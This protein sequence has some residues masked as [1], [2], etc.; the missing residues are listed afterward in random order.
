MT[1]MD[2]RLPMNDA[3]AHDIEFICLAK[4]LIDKVDEIIAPRITETT[5]ELIGRRHADI[6]VAVL[7]NARME[8]VDP[9]CTKLQTVIWCRITLLPR[10]RRDIALPSLT[11]SI[12]D[13][14]LSKWV[15]TRLALYVSALIP[16]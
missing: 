5:P 2:K 3:L 12:I 15:L 13:K 7:E 14:P 6:V 11:D 9:A 10:E 4:D 16:E 1:L 8:I